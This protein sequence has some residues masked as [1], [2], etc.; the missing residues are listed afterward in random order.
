MLPLVGKAAVILEKVTR[1]IIAWTDAHPQLTKFLAIAVAAVGA[2]MLVLGPFLIM[3][4]LLAAFR[5]LFWRVAHASWG[6][7]FRFSAITSWK[8]RASKPTSISFLKTVTSRLTPTH[9][10][11]TWKVMPL[12]RSAP[13]F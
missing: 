1:N 8:L 9:C 12:H 2:L 7:V 3:L 5:G 10:C 6:L 4:P 11:L 13:L